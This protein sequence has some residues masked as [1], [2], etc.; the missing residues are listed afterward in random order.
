MTVTKRNFQNDRHFS[1]VKNMK[2]EFFIP[3]IPPTVTHQE[4]SVHVVHGKPVF[5]EPDELKAARV[6]LR[7]HLARY[8]PAEKYIGAVRLIVKWSF[9]ISGNH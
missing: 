9:P 5:Y 1:E 2:T 7:D 8:I 3:M 4:K 6:K